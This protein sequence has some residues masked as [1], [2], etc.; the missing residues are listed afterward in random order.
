MSRH[1]SRPP[2]WHDPRSVK[3]KGTNPRLTKL[4]GELDAGRDSL[5]ARVERLKEANDRLEGAVKKP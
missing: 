5:A 1:S 4:L 2:A 3:L